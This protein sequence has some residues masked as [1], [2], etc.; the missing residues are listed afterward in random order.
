VNVTTFEI[1]V[2]ADRRH[3]WV[4]LTDELVRAVKDSGVTEGMAIMYCTHT[5]CGLVINEREDG[6]MGDF[7]ARLARLVPVTGYYA[8][9]DLTRRTQNL[10]ADERRNGRAHVAQM[11]LGGTSQVVPVTAGAPA[12]GR[13]QRPMLL[14]LDDPK[15]RTCLIQVWG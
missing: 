6:A 4:D 12:L 9:D 10:V 8:H 5:T 13:W 14:E 15:P 2:I 1:E 3:G 7:E 11:L